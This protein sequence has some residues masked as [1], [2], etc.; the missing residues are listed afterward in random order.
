M[1]QD[2]KTQLTL[3]LEPSLVER[4]ATLREFLAHR[5]A[6]QAK[7]AKTIAAEMDMSPSTLSRKLNPGE[8]DTSRFNVDDLE[9]YLART[10]DVAAVIEYLASKFAGG[11]DD[12][13]LSRLMSQAESAAATL[14]HCIAAIQEA[15]NR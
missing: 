6:V 5:V 14:A 9:S 12:A 7:P 10:G 3:S 4:W 2:S 11:G 8:G 15:R 1:A 13:R